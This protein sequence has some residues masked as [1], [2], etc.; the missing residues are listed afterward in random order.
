MSTM[1][2]QTTKK[3]SLALPSTTKQITPPQNLNLKQIWMGISMRMGNPTT[4]ARMGSVAL[5][6]GDGKPYAFR[7]RTKQINYAIPP[8]LEEV[9]P[10]KGPSKQSKGKGRAG[11]GWSANGTELARYMGGLPG[12]DSVSILIHSRRTFLADAFPGL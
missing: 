8:P 10:V 11:P 1:R 12:D 5:D 3:T 2:P 7:R 9:R 6:D 4:T